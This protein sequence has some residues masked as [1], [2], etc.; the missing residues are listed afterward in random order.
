MSVIQKFVKS[1]LCNLPTSFGRVDDKDV[2]NKT[3]MEEFAIQMI[4][5]F[6]QVQKEAQQI[7]SQNSL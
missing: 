5:T 6:L 7:I 3:Q 4:E 1:Q 2:Y